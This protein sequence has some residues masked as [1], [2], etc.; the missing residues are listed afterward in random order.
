MKIC[1][2]DNPETMRRECWQNGIM[3]ASY[4]WI[5]FEATGKLPPSKIMHLG[6]DIGKWKK[7]QFSGDKQAMKSPTP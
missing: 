7:G 4:N 6:V 3:Q 2:F 1:V 5:E